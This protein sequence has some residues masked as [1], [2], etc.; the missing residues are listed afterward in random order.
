[1]ARQITMRTLD[2]VEATAHVAYMF[3]EFAGIYPITPSTGMG[4]LT[5]Q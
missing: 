5:D 1:M 4:E 2:G 3:T